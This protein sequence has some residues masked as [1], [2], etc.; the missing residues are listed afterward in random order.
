MDDVEWSLHRLLLFVKRVFCFKAIITIT[1]TV[2]KDY[3]IT[4]MQDGQ[5]VSLSLCGGGNKDSNVFS[6]YKRNW[7]EYL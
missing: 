3:S 6:C 7:A 5:E 4:C 2:A 1:K